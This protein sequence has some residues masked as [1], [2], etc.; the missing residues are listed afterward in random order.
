METETEGPLYM[1]EKTYFKERLDDQIDWYG[2]KS[3]LNKIWFTRLKKAEF[4]LTASIPLCSIFLLNTYH[5][6]VTTGI[7]GAIVLIIQSI[8]GL[9]NYQ[10]LWIEYRS[11]AET[12]K[13]EKFMYLT[14]TGI[15]SEPDSELRFKQLVERSESIISHENVNWAQLQKSTPKENK[16]N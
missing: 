5:L 13:H 12:L 7:L 9:S 1:D 15:Y 4:I 6:K 10:E 3:T 2:K 16:T 8:H 14:R 11:V